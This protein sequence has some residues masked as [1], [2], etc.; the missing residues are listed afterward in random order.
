[1][2]YRHHRQ[3]HVNFRF[4]INE[5]RPDVP[6]KTGERDSRRKYADYKRP[7]GRCHFFAFSPSSTRRRTA[8][9]REIPFFEAQSSIAWM[10][11]TGARTVRRGSLPVAGRPRLLGCTFI[12]FFMKWVVP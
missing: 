8:A 2:N 10:T 11:A 5:L 9:D 1:M 6:D 4:R 3:A 7:I 12:D